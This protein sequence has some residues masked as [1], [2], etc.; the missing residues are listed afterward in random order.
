MSDMEWLPRH[1]A[2]KRLNV[3]PNT[4][5]SRKNRGLIETKKDANG[6]LLFAVPKE[7]AKVTPDEWEALR[8]LMPKAEVADEKPVSQGDTYTILS[9]FD[10]HVPDA[11]AFAVRAILDFARDR[12]PNHIVLG[13]DFLE[14]ESC[15]QHGGNP[16]PL[17]LV[18]EIKAGRK[19]L[20]RIREACPNAALTTWRETMKQDCIE[21]LRPI[22]PHSTGLSTFQTCLI[23]A[24]MVASG[25]LIGSYGSQRLL[26]GS[27]ASCSTPMA[28]GQQCTTQPSIS[29]RMASQ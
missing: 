27:K 18:D 19:T 29:M 22:Y 1:A 8:E 15:S 21:S 28:S 9:L 6:R 4:L 11:D 5:K 12:Q 23:W 3:S 10:V 25:C 26:M 20:D 24:V 7:S 17:A 2:A 14:L 16:S 13:G